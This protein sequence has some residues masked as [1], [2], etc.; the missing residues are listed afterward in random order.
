MRK[1]SLILLLLLLVLL[2]LAG[3]DART[4]FEAS[5][6][7]DERA[8]LATHTQFSVLFDPG[9]APLEY[10]DEQGNPNGMSKEYLDRIAESTGLTFV[11]APR[12]SWQEGY[13][14]L[15]AGQIDMTTSVTP[16]P[17]RLQ[18]L[19]FTE[20][21]LTIPLAIIAGNQ[22]GYIGNLQELANRKV[23][24][25]KGYGA[26]EWLAQDYPDLILVPVQ[27]VEEGLRLVQRGEAFCMIE[28]LLV[29]NHYLTLLNLNTELRVVGNTP[30][31]NNLS[32]AVHKSIAPLASILQKALVQIDSEQRSSIYRKHLSLNLQRTIPLSTVY[33]IIGIGFG[34]F[35]LLGFWIWSLVRE[36]KRREYAEA[37]R[38]SSERKFKQ[39][40]SFAPMP[41]ALIGFTGE[42]LSANDRWYEVFGYQPKTI[43]T[44]DQWFERAYPEASYRA[45]VRTLWNESI[46]DAQEKN[47][48]IIEKHEYRV[49]AEGDRHY[50][51]E[52]SGTLLSD[53]IMV[54]F[55]DIT[56]RKQRIEELRTLNQEA[57]HA[58]RIILSALEDQTQMHQVVERSNATLHAAI[59]SMTD[60]LFIIDTDTR[61]ILYNKAFL[62][63][64]RFTS[65]QEC[66]PSLNAFKQLFEAYQEN[67]EIL[68][69]EQWSSSLALSG[70]TGIKEYVFEKR[71]T[72]QRWIGSYSYAPI[73]D[74]EGKSLGA[75]VVCRDVTET[76]EAQKR[77]IF[78][79]N[80]DYLTGLFSRTYLEGEL[81]TM[82][83]MFPLT[84]GIVDVNGLKL[85]NDSFG[86]R[87]GD[88]ILKKTAQL[89][90]MQGDQEM[91][92]ARY[93]GDE[94]VF[95]MPG[96]DGL[97]AEAYFK[98]VEDAAKLVSIEE[99]HL[100]LSFGHATRSSH[101]EDL[102]QVLKKAED[103][104]NR[105]KLYES[106]SAKNKSI[107]LVINSLFAKSNR[108]SQH[109]RRVSA[110]CAYLTKQLQ[111]SERE[112]NRMKVAGLMHDIGKIGVDEAILNKPDRLDAAE[113]EV[114]RR[115]PEIGYRIL[116]ASSEFTDLARAVLEHHERWDGKGYP[117]GLK[118]EEISY[119]ARIIMITDSYDA[120]T[121]ERSYK[122][123]LS[124]QE[125][126]EEI[127]RC[128]GTHYDPEIVKVFLQTISEF[129][130]IGESV[131]GQESD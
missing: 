70:K 28:N 55:I 26:A 125:A 73:I 17:T 19:V 13:E 36:M 84:L 44:I 92:I 9:W 107:A 50:D 117:R 109:S 98:R 46:R 33:L 81:R 131:Q 87:M 1:R 21:F 30:Y 71:D 57:E 27:N 105:N 80:H 95:V 41:M 108:E 78:Q 69:V 89:L 35:A 8:F 79:R 115:H 93:G 2:P 64:Y 63:Y 77:L 15:L 39:L 60:A 23:A 129:G 5:L 103:S 104:M 54:T 40:F 75:V 74:K 116:S 76:K 82:R 101:Q 119:Q 31:A 43:T 22:V 20:P 112:V 11:P 114:M 121:S 25:V 49:H 110:L 32:M 53:C 38:E 96:K 56:E 113:W 130:G 91:L 48:S 52:I 90:Q 12:M 88:A 97:A 6:D 37:E 65:P 68:P 47:T 102:Q 83:S 61:F 111:L 106:A 42:V 72:K 67:G 100:S 99:I 59:N 45:E 18:S 14:L 24:V 123:P 34:L 122:K 29:T 118:G 58:R 16:T 127:Q 3:N 85:I 4:R 51:M 10:F 128:S 66:P 126:I 94:F 86:S 7:D 124:H 120:M 62:T